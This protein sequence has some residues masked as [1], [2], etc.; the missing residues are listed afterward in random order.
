MDEHFT[1]LYPQRVTMGVCRVVPLHAVFATFYLGSL[2]SLETYNACDNYRHQVTEEARSVM[3]G[4]ME[5][6]LESNV[7]FKD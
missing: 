2:T 5:S 6:G 1:Q 4:S 3:S 7:S